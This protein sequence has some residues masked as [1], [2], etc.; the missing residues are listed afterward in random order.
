MIDVCIS[1]AHSDFYAT[2]ADYRTRLD[3]HRKYAH[4]DFDM[5]SSA[6]E[7]IKNEEVHSI[8][9]PQTWTEGKLVTELGG[10]AHVPVISFTHRGGSL[11]YTPSPYFIRRTP[12]DL[13]QAKAFASICQG[14]EWHEAVVLYQ[15]TNYATRFLSMLNKAFQDADIRLAHVVAISTLAED[16]HIVNELEKLKTMQTRVFLVHMNAVLG[17]RLFLLAQKADMMSEGYAWLVT[18]SLGN[19]LNSIDSAAIECMEGVLGLRAH[20]P[21]T[22]NLDNFRNRWKKNML[23][24]K[25]ESTG[26]ELNVYGLWAYDTVWALAMAV[27]NIGPVNPVLL[28]IN[29]S[30]SGSDMFG[31]QISQIGPKLVRE[32]QSITFQGLTGE[33]YLIDG[34]LKASALEIVNVFETGDKTIG[35]WTPDQGIMPKLSLSTRQSYSTSI[36]ELKTIIWPGDSVKHPK[37]VAIQKLRVG[38]PKKYEFINVPDNLHRNHTKI[39]GYALDIF[40]AVMVQLNFSLDYEIIPFTIESGQCNRTYNALLHNVGKA[41]D[42]AVG[43]ITI[44]ADRARYVDFTLPYSESGTV[45][46]VRNKKGKGMWSFVKPFRWDLWLTIMSACIFIGIVLRLLEHRE[47]EKSDSAGTNNQKF[48]FLFWFPISILAFPEKNMVAS[49]WSRFVLVVWLLMA[50]IMMQSYTAKLSAIFTVDQ[51]DFRFSN[52][53]YIGIQ[54]GS[55][56]KDFLVDRLH[57]NESK[58]KEYS[59]IEDYHYAM[60]KGSENGGIDAIFDEIPYMKLFLD[61]HDSDYKIVGTTF[62]TG[63]FGF[64]FP[65]KSPLV[66]NFSRAI[67]SVTEDENMGAIEQG[68]SGPKYSPFNQSDS[69]NKQSLSLTAFDFGGLFILV[70]SA[71]LFALFCSET[72]VGQKL[73]E[74]VRYYHHRCSVFL[75]FGG[76]E[77]KVNSTVNPDRSGDSFSEKE[78]GPDD[79]DRVNLDDSSGP[80]T[81]AR[82]SEQRNADISATD[83]QANESESEQRGI[84]VSA[85]QI[86]S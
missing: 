76:N 2:H 18:D 54:K 33:F 48:G 75:S 73:T 35:Y 69:V 50:Y 38:V 36:K 25:P 82:E 34:Q 11:S 47:N 60:N 20:V 13:D 58:I 37:G 41:F 80:G 85:K 56:T 3:I 84:A 7:L 86:S 30:K 63:G 1:M 39:T 24:M 83:G 8:L 57:V 70:A 14:F 6:L 77:P 29:N 28:D 53:Y 72:S 62:R 45:F 5:T 27:E 67:L 49:H 79:S 12:N 68:N 78:Q 22:K 9:G 52:D 66:V 71:L 64:A 4:N 26:R 81:P 23:L 46:V 21:K 43:D 31:V 44:L 55:F 61:Q 15:D 42:I 65:L 19:S 74:R 59:T 17:S 10:K 40:S 16:G 51:L 32:L